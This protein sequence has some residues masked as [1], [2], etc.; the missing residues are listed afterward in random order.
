M[1]RAMVRGNRWIRE[2]AATSLNPSQVETTLVQLC[3]RWPASAPPFV[4]V[5]Q[6]FPLGEASL[7]HLLAVSSICATRLTRNPETLLWLRQPEICLAPRGYAEML[8]ELGSVAGDAI[9]GQNF[10]ALRFWKGREMTRIALRELANLASLEETTAELSHI[11]EICVRRVFEHWNGEFRKRYG[12]PHAEFAILALGKLG[13]AELNHS[14]D[15]DLLFLYSEEGHL[16]PQFSYHEFFNRLGKKILETFSTRHPEGSLFRVDLRLR[17]EGS[18]GPL[19]RSLESM[20]NY[21]AGFGET[22][23]RLALIKAC[24]IAGSRELAYEFLRQHQP[25]IYPKSTTPDLLDEIANIKRRIERD[26]VGPDNLE[27]DV[28][29][30]RGGIREIEFIVQALQLIHGAQHPFLQEASML[31]ALRALRELDLLPRD[32]VLTLDNTYRFLR[33]VEHRLQIEAE[34]QTHTVPQEPEPLQRLALSLRFSSVED[35]TA[36]L[37]ERMRAVRPI[38]QRITSETSPNDSGAKIGLEIFNDQK[39]AAKTLADLARRQGSFHIAPRTRQVFSKLR[40]VLLEWLARAADPDA[41]LNQFVRFVEAY[42]LR[43]L[44]F[45]LL[46]TN[47]RLLELLVKTFDA[48][49]FAGDLLIR[50]PQLLEEITRDPAFYQPRSIDENLRRLESLGANASKLD[51]VRAYRRRQ[52]LRIVLRDALGLTDPL[53]VFNELSDLAEACLLFTTRLLGAEELTII[54]LGKFGGR[55]ISYGADLDV[56]IVGDDVRSAQN[57]VVAMTQATAEGNIWVLDARL[58]PE[59]E[60]GPL[61]CSLESYQSYYAGRAQPWELQVLTR[62]RAVKGPLQS[63]FIEMAKHVWR[64]AGQHVDLRARIDNMLERIR[65]DRGSGSDFLDFKTGF[66][67][68]IEAEFLVQALQMRENIWEANWER[69]VDLLRDHGRLTESEAGKLGHAYG[70][71]RRGEA[72]LRRYDNKSVS[73]FPSDP[74]EQRKLAIRL[75]YE[76]F[77]AFREKY[78]DA[79][80]TIHGL[81][82]QHINDPS[83]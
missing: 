24:G 17:P 10:A 19:A 76:D 68:I 77:D 46:V 83:D 63:E 57:L 74:N 52:L 64:N 12:S 34:Q 7:L 30:G 60:K 32:E 59:G 42:G 80:E 41:T 11:A 53:A 27:R 26:V 73:V 66:G 62:A 72:V 79:R 61:V 23:E 8:N 65:R 25:F 31:R 47:P 56:L 48:S 70:F 78:V 39:H 1:F 35:F 45:E 69:A 28:K 44:L 75:G 6:Q 43:S 22:W 40:P 18:A 58:R 3:E 71:L 36:A 37:Q 14:S 5:V 29:L 15:V 38:F 49:R 55:E 33:R 54:A 51:P 4:D 13:G 20:E 16:T 82:D 9:T 2:K 50:H 81:Y 67:G 21:Y